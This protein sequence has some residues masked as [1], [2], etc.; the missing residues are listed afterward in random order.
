MR[1]TGSVMLAVAGTLMVLAALAHGLAGWPSVRQALEESH[2]D[3]GLIIGIGSGW[4][5][6]S[7]SMLTFGLMTLLAWRAAANGD[8]GVVR[9][10]GPISVLYAGFGAAVLALVGLEPH[11]LG[12]VVIGLLAGFGAYAVSRAA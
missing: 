4:L 6:G 9:N 3:P 8:A 5:F 7:A 2:T 11:F 12:F 1:R 10:V